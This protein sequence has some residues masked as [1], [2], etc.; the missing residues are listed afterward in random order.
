MGASPQMVDWDEDGD[1][2]LIVG[3]SNGYIHYFKNFGTAANPDLRDQG[4]V[5]AGG[6]DIHVSS[7]AIPV[8]HDWD[9]DGR[10]D[11]VLGNN[12]PNI[13][14]YLNV[15]TNAAPVFNS[16]SLI[17]TTPEISQIK[18]APDI[19]DLNGDGLKDLAFG[20]WQGTVVYY[21]NSGTNS[22]P[23]FNGA[24]LLTALGDTIQPNFPTS[25]WTHLELNDWDED[26][27]LDLVYGEWDGHVNVYLNATGDLDA[28]LTPVNPPIIIPA[29]GGSFSFLGEVQNGTSYPAGGVVWTAVLLPSGSEFGPLFQGSISVPAGGAL[30]SSRAQIVPNSAPPGLYH[31]YLRWGI[32]PASFWAQAEFTFTKLGSGI[33]DSGFGEWTNTGE[34]FEVGVTRSVSSVSGSETTPTTVITPNP[35]NPSTVISF[36][37]RAASFVSL[38]VYDTAGRLVT[39]LVDGWR[40]VGEHEVTFDGSALPSGVYLAKLTS[41]DFSAVQKLVLLK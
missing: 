21:P 9:E 41:G 40:E 2:D 30:S 23:V 20:W 18:N 8:I 25:G 4:H 39:T 10:K 7:L 1:K 15:G 36:E 38:R 37:L 13:R 12:D 14:L 5:Q 24:H 32:P 27:D 3:E 33:Q 29:S 6:S 26:G 17:P 16:Y 31:Y 19:G 34:E 22:N 11:L 28:S 35:F